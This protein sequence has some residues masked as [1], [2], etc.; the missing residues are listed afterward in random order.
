MGN[1]KLP[2]I[3]LCAESLKYFGQ[4][5]S[6]P[7]KNHCSWSIYTMMDFY[8]W[9]YREDFYEFSTTEKTTTAEGLFGNFFDE[10]TTEET[11]IYEPFTTISELINGS[12][13]KI[14]E[15]LDE[16]MVGQSFGAKRGLLSREMI[17]ET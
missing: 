16:Y 9:C 2:A 5:R 4:G 14:H 10:S 11:E 12:T 1:I 15:M 13:L 7:L 8:N 3:T 6:N 17:K